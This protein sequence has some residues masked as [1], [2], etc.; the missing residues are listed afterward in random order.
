[1]HTT[2]AASGTRI[3]LLVGHAGCS[4]RRPATSRRA[5]LTTRVSCGFAAGN[6]GPRR[7]RSTLTR[8]PPGH[9]SGLDAKG[10]QAPGL[11]RGVDEELLTI[12][13]RGS[14]PGY[15]RRES[16]LG[17]GRGRDRRDRGSGV[18]PERTARARAVLH[19]VERDFVR[20]PARRGHRGPDARGESAADSLGNSTHPAG[21]R[22]SRSGARAREGGAGRLDAWAAVSAV[23]DPARPFG[24]HVARW[25]DERP[26]DIVHGP[27]VESVHTVPAGGSLSLAVDV[28]AGATA[29]EVALAWGDVP[30]LADLDV[31]VLDPLARD[32]ELRAL[33]VHCLFGAPTASSSGRSARNAHSGI[34]PTGARGYDIPCRAARSLRSADRGLDDL[35]GLAPIDAGGTS[36]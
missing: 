30:G 27:A 32:R 26:Y 3:G 36:R 8:S 29:W 10:R 35:Y 22:D 11:L 33:N 14:R 15:R 6:Q 31:R 5:S 21:D 1:M 13:A 18:R 34:S 23:R 28:A 25:L 20:R 16:R 19:R 12:R 17:H 24:T 4:I 2:R 7:T 9:R